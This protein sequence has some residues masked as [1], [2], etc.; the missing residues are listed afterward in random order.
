MV[1]GSCL[2]LSTDNAP[3]TV[4][5]VVKK[6]PRAFFHQASFFARATAAVAVPS[7]T[8]TAAPFL[9]QIP[10]RNPRGCPGGL[11]SVP[12]AAAGALSTGTRR[13]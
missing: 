8:A 4:Q 9:S 2:S 10:R 7:L 3:L 1:E 5:G 6:S 11:V 12:N 13:E